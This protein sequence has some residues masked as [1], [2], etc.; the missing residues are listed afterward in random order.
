L[1]SSRRY[2]DVHEASKLDQGLTRNPR[3]ANYFEFPGRGIG[4][5]SREE[6]QRAIQLFDNVRALATKA[7]SSNDAE[8]LAVTRVK[9][10]VNGYIELVSMGSMLPAR[11][12][13]VSLTLPT[14]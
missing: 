13:R 5:P 6:R 2:A 14:I 12:V 1:R 9:A 8:S 11:G 3:V 7:V 10:I 4:H